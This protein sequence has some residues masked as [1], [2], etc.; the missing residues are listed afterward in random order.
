MHLL[1]FRTV[2]LIFFNK[3]E[4]DIF[5][6]EEIDLLAEKNEKYVKQR[7][8][9]CMIVYCL[10]ILSYLNVLTKATFYMLVYCLWIYY[11]IHSDLAHTHGILHMEIH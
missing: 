5:W 4:K 8:F 7:H 2:K 11:L 3:E 9:S 1:H 6:R 10:C